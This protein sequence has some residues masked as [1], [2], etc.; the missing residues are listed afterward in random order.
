M[1]DLPI[2]P[3]TGKPCTMPRSY[4]VT[5][6]DK[7]GKVKSISL[8]NL[9]AQDHLKAKD[10]DDVIISPIVTQSQA[11]PEK[12]DDPK[13][14]FK[15][16]VHLVNFLDDIMDIPNKHPKHNACP[17]CKSTLE[18]IAETQRLGCPS[19]YNHFGTLLDPL[20][21]NIQK[22]DEIQHVGKVPKNWEKRQKEKSVKSKKALEALMQQAIDEEKYEDAAKLRDEIKKIVPVERIDGD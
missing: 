17:S 12:L 14:A 6:V 20:L 15:S 8:C 10:E 19:C 16:V 21:A 22:V 9:C 11:A 1:D 5:D 3:V 2:C 18:D 13:K 4:S 7:D